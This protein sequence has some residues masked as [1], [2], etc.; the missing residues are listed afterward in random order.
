MKVPRLVSNRV[1]DGWWDGGVLVC[2]K[3]DGVVEGY[4]GGVRSRG[5][6]SSGVWKSGG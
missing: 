3:K 1:R 5:M 6:M 2:G 4:W